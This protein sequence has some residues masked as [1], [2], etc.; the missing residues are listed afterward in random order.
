MKKTI[1]KYFKII[2]PLALFLS[3]TGWIYLS[4]YTY[5][6]ALSLIKE[7]FNSQQLLLAKQMAVGIEEH[8]KLL[9]VE[10]E[11]L[12]QEAAIKNLSLEKSRQSVEKKF[13]HIK[14]HFL[15]DIGLIDHTGIVRV[16]FKAPHFEGTYFLRDNFKKASI[17]K[18]SSALFGS[19]LLRG[20]DVEQRGIVITMPFFS[21]KGYF[22]GVGFFTITIN[23]LLQNF[24]PLHSKDTEVYIID[25]FGNILC[26][27]SN[28]QHK[29]IES[30]QIT[31]VSYK[32]FIEEAKAG[33][34]GTGKYRGPEG[35]KNVIV[36][37]PL[38][39]GDQPWSIVISKPEAIVSTLL[40]PFTIKFTFATLIVLLV[41]AL[42]SFS[43]IYLI[44][45]WN[46]EL[47]AMVR[48]RTKEL[49][50]NTV[51]LEAAR[52]NLESKVEE[53]TMEL[54]NAHQ[55][56]VK[57]EK[58]AVVGEMASSVSHE[59][60]NPL[61]VIKNAIYFLSMHEDTFKNEELKDNLHIIM[62]EI[63]TANKIISDLLDFTRD[64]KPIRLDINLNQLVK[65]MLSKASIPNN[66]KVTTELT[67][68]MATVS[69]D[70]TQVAQIILN[71]VDNA[72]QSM[73]EGGT[74]T[75]ATTVT[76]GTT[77]IIFTDEG[78]G[79]SKENLER[80]FDPLF[81]TKTKG[82]GLGLAIS[83]SMAETNGGSIV[84]ES[85]GKKGSTFI[86]RFTQRSRQWNIL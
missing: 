11:D 2:F 8:I 62:R 37:Y 82:I 67:E 55:A 32:T 19:L 60:R 30:L 49:E 78:C 72:V 51:A 38:K 22:A 6:D 10:L 34:I 3:L 50:K 12:T 77:D 5:T 46:L 81:T 84:V 74:L 35:I 61:G 43:I 68:D 26:N 31:D 42:T 54:K 71:L 76:N 73:E 70:P 80:I 52:N 29:T 9:V 48:T 21:S 23:E 44:Y 65:E 63:N 25:K 18:T 13:Y 45:K 36:S 56:L 64:K 58:L 20:S 75:I 33:R 1:L 69:I 17:L 40:K 16:S 14:G 7:Q 83:K 59:L 24:I 86:V 27:P 85:D 15:N 57:K 47:D 41:V 28:P 66:I 79:I 39:I 4:Y 53:R